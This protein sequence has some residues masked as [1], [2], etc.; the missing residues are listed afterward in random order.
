MQ[1]F[2]LLFSICF[3]LTHTI[4]AQQET[5]LQFMPTVWQGSKIN[6][7]A[8]PEYKVMV[9]LP[10]I[11][12]SL[13]FSGPTYG[14]AI[15]E[16]NGMNVFDVD[17]VLSQLGER[18]EVRDQL[19]IETISAAMR[20]GKVVVGFHHAF[21]FNAYFNYPETLPQ[22]I[23]RGNAQYIGQTIDMSN[24]IHIS[25]Y[26]E[27]GLSGAVRLFD[28]TLGARVKYLTGIAD[29]STA[30][31]DLSLYTD[32]DV[33]QLTLGADYLVN[34]SALLDYNDY[35]DFNLNYGFGQIGGAQLFTSN[36]GF[37]FDLGAQLD[38]GP[39]TL[40]ASVVD[41]GSIRWTEEVTNYSAK[42]EFTYEGLD[43][44]QALTGDSV[45]FEG[46]LDTLQEIFQFQQTSEAY[47]TSLPTKV[48][49]NGQLEL[50]RNW[51]VGASLMSEFYR[52]QI[53]GALGLNGTVRLLPGLTLGA[54]YT[55]F[56]DTYANFGLH[57]AV[58]L[59]PVQVFALTDNVLAAFRPNDSRFFQFRTGVNLVFGRM[60]EE[61]P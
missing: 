26:N 50:G 41:L 38:L 34:S 28:L 4:F 54:S 33:Y 40:G 31:N 16:E 11:H 52:G 10:G 53:Y 35:T 59:G 51:I 23:W 49:L 47:T 39:L 7:A 17:Q 15:R 42:G 2:L 24:D 57:A 58:D 5:G 27:I 44:S 12:N 19:E 21:R 13:F 30:R 48:F 8:W 43:I 22:L 55:L 1:R 14:D 46:A 25:S 9:G 45:T 61:E 36:R 6:P 37:A 18:N 29:L 20:F 56:R 3:L 60:E 32:P